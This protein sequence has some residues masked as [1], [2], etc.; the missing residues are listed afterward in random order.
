MNEASVTN[1]E[2]EDDGIT[3]ECPP[4][5]VIDCHGGI[6]LPPRRSRIGE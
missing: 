6:I 1:P 5:L 4:P 3:C 2:P